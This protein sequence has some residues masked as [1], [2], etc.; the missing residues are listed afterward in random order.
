ME[1]NRGKTEELWDLW[2]IYGGFMVDLWWIDGELLGIDG[3]FM[4]IS[5]G[6]SLDF[7]GLTEISWDL[8]G[9]ALTSSQRSLR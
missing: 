6:C 5:M 3:D 9:R 1:K 7:V 8:D 4:E 2:V